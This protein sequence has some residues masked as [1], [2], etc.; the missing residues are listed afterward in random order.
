[1]M[2]RQDVVKIPGCSMIEANGVAHEFLAGDRSHPR[3]NEIEDMLE[4]MFTR[5]KIVGYAPSTDEVLLDI[6][7]DEKET[8][9][10]RHSEKLAIAFGLIA[11]SPPTPIRI[12]KNLRICNDCHAAA[13]LISKAF[14]REIVVRDRHQFHHFK[15]G[16]CSCMEYW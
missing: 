15:H 8:N 11:T 3:I 7:E 12:I 16:S 1:M 13:K 5:L 2:M 14:D 4:D 10:F 6:D 9:L